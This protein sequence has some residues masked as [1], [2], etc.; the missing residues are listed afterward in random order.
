[1]SHH[2]EGDR[3][4]MT[5]GVGADDHPEEELPF[6]FAYEDDGEDN[7]YEVSEFGTIDRL[8]AAYQKERAEE[9]EHAIREQSVGVAMQIG[10]TR[11]GAITASSV[12]ADAEQ[13]AAYLRGKAA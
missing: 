5:T 3:L 9:R 12:I 8:N 6:P 13:I 1:M 7:D 11:G 2:T 4:G 10:M